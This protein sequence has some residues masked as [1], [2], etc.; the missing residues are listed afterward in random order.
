MHYPVTW[1]QGASLGE[2]IACE[3]RLQIIN[4]NIKP[5]EVLSENRIAADFGTS[6]SPVR[7]ALKSLSGEGLIRLE[8]MGAVVVGLNIKDVKE[9]Y[10]VRYLIESFAQ[11][12][13]AVNIQDAL[14]QQLEQ[15]IDK[16]KLAVKHN[17]YVEFAHQDFSFHEAIVTE[18]NHTRILHLWN[19]IRYIVMTVILITT[20]KGFTLGEAR[21][22]WVADKHR[23]VVE[24]LRSGDPETIHKVVQEYFADSGET[25]IRSLP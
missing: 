23:T 2:S 7:E 13:L 10:D 5:G 19:S 20:E 12:R 18:A 1:L 3:L 21:M 22:N 9:L 24:A 6:R 15:S 8:R 14:I 17:D 16:M 11:Q 4:E 25:L